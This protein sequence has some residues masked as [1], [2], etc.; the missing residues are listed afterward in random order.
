MD[1]NYWLGRKY[2]LLGQNTAA[3]TA[4]AQAGLISAN[5]GAALDTVR[6]GLLPGQTAADIAESKARANLTAVNATLAPGLAKAS[7]AAS[8]GS[9]KANVAQAGLYGAQTTAEEQS[10]DTLGKLGLTS[11][12]IILQMLK[13][14][15]GLGLQ[16]P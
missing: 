1:W 4:R 10:S 9:A 6:A 16:L 7:E 15:G 11:N 3:D 2:D 13:R 12:P 14:L 8:Y 5:S